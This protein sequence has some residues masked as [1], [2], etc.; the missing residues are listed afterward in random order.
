MKRYT[1]LEKYELERGLGGYFNPVTRQVKLIDKT[2][3][4][5]EKELQ[6]LNKNAR[7]RFFKIAYDFNLKTKKGIKNYINYMLDNNNLDDN[8]KILN[9]VNEVCK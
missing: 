6:E 2:D 4:A 5:I 8:I 9:I 3:K 1:I 7:S